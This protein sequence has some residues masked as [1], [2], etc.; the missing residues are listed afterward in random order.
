VMAEG[1]WFADMVSII[2][3]VDITMGE[4]DR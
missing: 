2:S 3:S 4:V 1:Q